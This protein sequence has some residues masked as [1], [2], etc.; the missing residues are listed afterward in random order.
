MPIPSRLRSHKPVFAS[1][2]DSAAAHSAA[3]QSTLQCSQSTLTLAEAD[4]ARSG[5]SLEQA[6]ADGMFPT[7]D[8]SSINPDFARAAAIIISYHDS[9]GRPLT[10]DRDGRA[11]LFCRA[12]YIVPP[13]FP[14]PRGRKYDQPNNSGTP[15]YF[16][17]CFDWRRAERGEIDACGLV[18]G[19]KKADALC[20]AGIPTFAIGGV[21]NFADSSAPLHPALAAVVEKCADLYVIFDSDIASNPKIEAAEWRLIGQAALLGVRV[22]PVRIPPSNEF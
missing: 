2:A 11:Q 9:D 22:H 5:L 20:R 21:W 7:D 10:Y 14:I 6:L 12:R 1:S 3:P 4:L 18:E 8:A 19:E 16:P 13:G 17:R 15:P